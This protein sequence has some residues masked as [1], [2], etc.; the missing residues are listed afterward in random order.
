[1]ALSS[2]PGMSLKTIQQQLFAHTGIH[3]ALRWRIRAFAR[4]AATV[5]GSVNHSPHRQLKSRP[6]ADSGKRSDSIASFLTRRIAFRFP[7]NFQST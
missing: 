5:S 2:M 7:N 1:M 6:S 4:R 3:T